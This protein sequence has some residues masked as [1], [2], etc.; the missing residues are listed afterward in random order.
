MPKFS[1]S[2]YPELGD[3]C[4]QQQAAMFPVM[5]VTDLENKILISNFP[6][7]ES[8]WVITKGRT[9]IT[10]YWDASTAYFQCT[11]ASLDILE[12][13]PP[14]PGNLYR[15]KATKDDFSVKL[16]K[17]ATDGVVKAITDAAGGDNI[18][19][20]LKNSKDTIGPDIA[21]ELGTDKFDSNKL[22]NIITTKYPTISKDNAKALANDILGNLSSFRIRADSTDPDEVKRLQDNPEWQAKSAEEI[23][24]IIGERMGGYIDKAITAAE[25]AASKADGTQS[26]TPADSPVG[27]TAN[28]SNT[29]T[30]NDANSAALDV[31][32]EAAGDAKNYDASSFYLDVNEQNQFNFEDDTA[33]AVVRALPLSTLDEI[34]IYMGYLPQMRPITADDLSENRLLRRGVWVIDTITRS[35]GASTGVIM[36]IQC[37][38]R[39]KYLMDTFGSYNTAESDDILVEDFKNF[40]TDGK[41]PEQEGV[42]NRI[43]NKRSDIILKIC[44]RGIGQSNQF[45]IGGRRINAGWI[46]DPIVES[47]AE[48]EQETRKEANDVTITKDGNTYTVIENG[49]ETTYSYEVIGGS[50]TFKKNGETSGREEYEAIADRFNNATPSDTSET[51]IPSNS[52]P[53]QQNLNRTGSDSSNDVKVQVEAANGDVWQRI[54]GGYKRVEPDG[55]TRVFY[56]DG[57]KYYYMEGGNT[58]PAPTTKEKYEDFERKFNENVYEISVGADGDGR[59]GIVNFNDG[60]VRIPISEGR[61]GI[62]KPHPSD[63]SKVVY[64]EYDEK[65]LVID[66]TA[67]TYDKNHPEYVSRL[68]AAKIANP[69]AF[70]RGSLNNDS[71]TSYGAADTPLDKEFDPFR[72]YKGNQTIITDNAQLASVSG[73]DNKLV[74]TDSQVDTFMNISDDKWVEIV[75]DTNDEQKNIIKSALKMDEKQTLTIADYKRYAEEFGTAL[76]TSVRKDGTVRSFQYVNSLQGSTVNRAVSKEMKFNIVTGRGAYLQNSDSYIGQDFIVTDR[77]PLDYVHYL[78]QQEPWPTVVFQDSRTGEFWYVPRGLDT[79]GLSDPKR[80]N[81]TYFFRQYPEDLTK[82]GFPRNNPHLATMIHSFREEESSISTR[83]NVL[84]QSQAP[85]AMTSNKGNYLHISIIPPMYQVDGGRAYAASFYT[86]TDNT[87]T[88]NPGALIATALSYARVLGKELKSAAATLLGD[89]SL[90]PGE[91]VQIIG[92]PARQGYVSD[93]SLIAKERKDFLEMNVQFESFYSALPDLIKDYTP[94]NGPIDLGSDWVTNVKGGQVTMEPSPDEDSADMMMVNAAQ[95]VQEEATNTVKFKPEPA[96]IWRVEAVIDKFNDGVD[97]YY[98]EVSLMSCF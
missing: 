53:D 13:I 19:D 82:L 76:F 25:E 68:E 45:S 55:T 67:V 95:D 11:L 89:P 18:I 86:V 16:N 97:G 62:Y 58:T 21:K 96:T 5:C 75:A 65:G 4:H 1:P 23:E 91:A 94:D 17:E 73:E 26:N 7:A 38:D 35:G 64:A 12:D 88:Q 39:L 66:G 79:S 85:K 59:G 74:S 43:I 27:T 2:F 51:A 92:S 78:A 54:D 30:T 40:S 61:T 57:D 20:S 80:F 81:R 24:G 69:G 50:Q 46:Y 8:P 60:S 15:R 52:G 3:K 90:I 37:R 83:T 14:P 31:K 77:A 71:G 48:G 93:P 47:E 9:N 10:T 49:E 22:I 56:Q 28:T 44:R 41:N 36:T 72:P 70:K 34:C 63:S 42:T 98:T 84:V 29:D 6:S 33:S 32:T 87:A